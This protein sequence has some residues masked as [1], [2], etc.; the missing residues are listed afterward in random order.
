MSKAGIPPKVEID[1]MMQF[2]FSDMFRQNPL[3][4]VLW[5]FPWGKKGSPL[6]R[7]KGPRKW[8]REELLAISEHI[9]NNVKLAAE[10]K[11]PL[12]Y[13]SGTA[14]GRG[15]GKSA[16]VAWLSL[17]MLSCIYGSTTIITANTDTQLSDKTFGEINVWFS[18]M[19]NNCFFEV[20]QKSIK[21]APWYEK[22]LKDDMQIGSKYF[23]VNGVLWNE[24]NPESFVG[25]HS[26]IGMMVLFDESSGVPE[27]IWTATKGFFTEKTIY[28]F[29]FAFS[30]PRSGAGAFFDIFNDPESGWRTR[31]LN[32]LDVEDLDHTEL[33]DIIRKY[34]EDS[35]EARV[36]VFGQFP[37][38]GDKQFI[39]RAIVEEA[40]RRELERYDNNEALVMGVDPARFGD[41]CTVVR[42][43]CGRDARSIPH[44]EYKGLDN[45][46]VVD[47]LIQLI[48]TYKPDGIFID[49]GAGAGIIDRLKQLGYK[50]HEVGFGTVSGEQHLY[51]HRTEL[52]SKMR[53]W[54]PGG[55]IDNHK[56]LK[57]DMCNPEKELIGRESKE[58]LESK[59]KMKKRG[60]KSPDHADALALTF[61]AKIAPKGLPTSRTGK[62]KRYRVQDSKIL[63]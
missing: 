23:Y 18:M 8:Q 44:Q 59:E 42:F 58:K 2:L 37:R 19:I 61:H 12:V 51:D 49:S 27:P 33:L 57:A 13:K 7:F 17:W 26:Q 36:E 24:D 31:Q 47:K 20:T 30:N 11:D 62:A 52:W 54:L 22:V 43:R 5:A 34:G 21:P 1:E 15:P 40:S 25:A 16:L 56:K 63:D 45:M 50:V 48:F 32:S 39:S 41:D 53:E 29:W 6:E 14:S 38:Q 28:R 10:G 55:M 35:D 9:K 3:A 60:L 4:F 46:E